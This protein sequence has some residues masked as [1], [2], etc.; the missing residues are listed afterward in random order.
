MDLYSSNKSSY[1]GVGTVWY[2]I[3]GNNYHCTLY[4]IPSYVGSGSTAYF[5]FDGT[6][7]YGYVPITPNFSISEATYLAWIYPNNDSTTYDGII[8]ER[9]DA[10]GMNY[11]EG[12]D[13]RSVGYGWNGN[14]TINTTGYRS[15]QRINPTSWN[16]VA[17]TIAPTEARFYVNNKPVVIRSGAA[18]THN[19]H[20][21][22]HFHIAQDPILSRI[23]G[24]RFSKA[25]VYD[26]ALSAQEIA[27][28][29]RVMKGRYH[30][31]PQENLALNLEFYNKDSYSGSGT[32]IY[33]ISGSM[34]SATASNGPVF[35]NL[36]GGMFTLDGVDDTIVTSS[37]NLTSTNKITVCFWA[38]LTNYTETTSGGKILVE[39]SSNYNNVR[40]A[41]VIS[42][43]EDS[44]PIFS[45]TFPIVLALIGNSN[46]YNLGCYSKTLVN[47][48]KW[49]FW[50]CIFDTTQSGLEVAFYLDGILRTP[51]ISYTVGSNSNNFGNYP[52][53]ISNRAPS[54]FSI[55]D[56][57]I[58]NG[59]L[60]SKAI[61]NIYESSRSRY[62]V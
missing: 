29:Y 24:G 39:F 58:Y 22:T 6:N 54:A 60:S 55:S 41:W 61:T 10:T 33:D 26:R 14:T 62:G 59:V 36:Y 18:I 53:Y 1:A 31:V 25:M 27:Q 56:F 40:D 28:N 57:H 20:T 7:D 15:A 17:L 51:T 2:D 19:P 12:D 3:S 4:N 34:L 44:S 11:G 47:D 42:C 37:L 5:L 49:H 52:V 43:A 21:L 50:T 46:G 30:N 32:S 38:K 45:S 35:S 23:F 16:Q 48:L 13:G 8:F 9:G